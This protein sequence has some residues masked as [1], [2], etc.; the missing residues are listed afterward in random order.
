MSTPSSVNPPKAKKPK[1]VR[2][3]QW[4]Y[5]RRRVYPN[6]SVGWIVDARTKTGGERKTFGTE[7]AAATFAQQC[8][9]ERE[10]N[11]VASFGN[12][13]LARYGKSV[14]DAIAFYLAHLR[15]LEASRPVREIVAAFLL[16]K[17]KLDK[18]SDR[19]LG[20]AR[21]RL[22][23]F[24]EVF[25]DRLI[26]SLTAEEITGW[27]DALGVGVVT[28]NTFRRRLSAVFSYAKGKK[29]LAENPFAGG[30]KSDVRRIDEPRKKVRI[31][32]NAQVQ[33]LLDLAS[34]ECLP[35][36][37][38]AVFAGLRPE[39]E[40]CRLH[41]S[42]ID[43]DQK[44]IVVD[45]DTS[46]IEE[47]KTGRRV[48]KMTDNLIAWLRR[49][50]GRTGLVAP[51]GDT[52]RKLRKDKRKAGFGTPGSETE[53]ERA[54]G[55]VLRQWTEDLTRHTYGSNHLAHHGDIGVTATQMGNSPEIVRQRYLALVKPVQAA[56][57]WDIA[58][59]SPRKRL[60]SSPARPSPH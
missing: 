1:K 39:S 24:I 6:G 10:N 38:I 18:R 57:F 59:Q 36:W 48:V 56:E 14:H 7:Q 41:W 60:T 54:E 2:Q 13:E 53:Q 42:D 37:A 49:F 8:R 50:I 34:D 4:P 16:E 46:E 20:D 44:V 51:Q 58:P 31:L 30:K 19:Y 52:W 25:G 22:E 33:K 32:S 9:V 29:W 26:S 47:T 3:R 40:I 21:T 43:F 55:V 35:F 27:L 11:G 23:R 5:V 15:K 17:E 12:A 45:G 28:R